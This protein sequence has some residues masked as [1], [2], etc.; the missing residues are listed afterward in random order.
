[1]LNVYGFAPD[2]IEFFSFFAEPIPGFEDDAIEVIATG[3]LEGACPRDVRRSARLLQ[4][5]ELDFWQAASAAPGSPL[6][7]SWPPN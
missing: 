5:Y 1:L 7:V 6:P 4:A 3:L 2:Q